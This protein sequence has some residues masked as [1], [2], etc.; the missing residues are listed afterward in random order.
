MGNRKWWLMAGLVGGGIV[1]SVWEYSKWRHIELDNYGQGR[2][3]SERREA[4]MELVE[5][6]NSERLGVRFKYPSGWVISETTDGVESAGGEIKVEVEP[7]RENL[8]DI[9]DREKER[10][11]GEGAVWDGERGYV[12]TERVKWTTFEWERGGK[13]WAEGLT[14][15]GDKLIK[16]VIMKDGGADW[17][18]FLEGVV[19]IAVEE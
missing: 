17:R 16:A 5:V 2:G 8:P 1:F 14:K 4:V 9:A 11:V 7:S 19:F 13:S 6:Y 18:Q 3:G 12:N 15:N 10:L